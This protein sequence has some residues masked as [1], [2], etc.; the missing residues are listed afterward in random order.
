MIIVIVKTTIYGD[1]VGNIAVFSLATNANE[2]GLHEMGHTVLDLQMNTNIM[3]VL[4]VERLATI[5]ILEASLVDQTL[6]LIQIRAPNKW[7]NLI[8]TSTPMP[9]TSNP[10]CTQFDS[11]QALYLKE[12]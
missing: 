9:T 2:I 6:L 12:L 8:L 11:Q 10:N 7:L 4:V 1:S 5:D 3:L